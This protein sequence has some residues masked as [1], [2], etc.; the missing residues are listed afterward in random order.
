MG[1]EPFDNTER[2]GARRLT[3][4]APLAAI[5]ITHRPIGSTRLTLKPIGLTW[6]APH[7]PDPLWQSRATPP[8]RGPFVWRAATNTPRPAATRSRNINRGN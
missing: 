1:L 7:A 6:I 4:G 2:D 3:A 8:I 5:T